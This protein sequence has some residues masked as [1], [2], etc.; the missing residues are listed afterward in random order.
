[1]KVPNLPKR[2][3]NCWAGEKPEDLEAVIRG[4]PVKGVFKNFAKSTG[5]HWSLFTGVSF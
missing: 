2:A 3:E 1:M 4:C 5:K